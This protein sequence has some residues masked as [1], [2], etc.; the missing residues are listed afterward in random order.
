MR[1]VPIGLRSCVLARMATASLI[2]GLSVSAW[3][4]PISAQEATPGTPVPAALTDACTA[5]TASHD[6]TPVATDAGTAQPGF[7][8]V[9]FDQL[10]IDTLASHHE[11]MI[12][13]TMIALAGSAQPEFIQ[14]ADA[15][16]LVSEGET[17]TLD[18]W[19]ADWFNG[20]APMPIEYQS[21]LLDEAL[22][23]T[24]VLAGSGEAPVLDP[25]LGAEYLCELSGTVP[26][27]LALID[28]LTAELQNGV[29]LGLSVISSAENDE[30][31]A[32][33]QTIV[34]RET[35]TIG[36]LAIWRDAWFGPTA[37]PVVAPTDHSHEAP[38]A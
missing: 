14:V 8:E 18:G 21:A 4:V 36:Q 7:D 16:R 33:G 34:D 32:L 27:D 23:A 37:A 17:A 22:A 35:A 11:A 20:S 38:A 29:A 13:L 28:L 15:T 19:R 24:S 25:L 10:A 26:L 1:H 9:A 12:A 6:A 2:L 30:L 3:S 5:I 31:A